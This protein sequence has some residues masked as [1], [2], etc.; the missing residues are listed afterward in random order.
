MSSCGRGVALGSLSSN[1]NVSI[2]SFI[3]GR[4]PYALSISNNAFKGLKNIQ[5]TV[6]IP[7]SVTSI[8]DGAF[9]K[10]YAITA[11][12]VDNTPNSITGSPW[13]WTNGTVEWLR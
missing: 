8:G 2:P 7:N 5:G 6:T 11:I 1:F 4:K 10:C 3:V 13:G 12:K 9:Y